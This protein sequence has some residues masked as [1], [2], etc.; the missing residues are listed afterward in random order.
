M[1]RRGG[2]S[3]NVTT[4]VLADYTGIWDVIN[5]LAKTFN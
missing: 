5:N 2:V 1:E 3:P 4:L